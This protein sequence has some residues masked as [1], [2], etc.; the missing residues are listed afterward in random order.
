MCARG[1][2]ARSALDASAVPPLRQFSLAAAAGAR[3]R[4]ATQAR[5]R[6][7][8]AEPRDATM[9]EV[10]AAHLEAWGSL[11]E[12]AEKLLAA[13]AAASDDNDALR[14]IFVAWARVECRRGNWAPAA[15]IAAEA[16]RA[17]VGDDDAQLSELERAIAAGD[18]RR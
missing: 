1:S 17:G 16:R 11:N 18:R 10:Q 6:C 5:R 14:R 13:C 2:R 4:R 9:L 15:T 7:S 8:A 3:G 12:S